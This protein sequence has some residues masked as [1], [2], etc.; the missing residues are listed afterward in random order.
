MIP[1]FSAIKHA[2]WT[3]GDIVGII[4]IENARPKV[5]KNAQIAN[6]RIAVDFLKRPYL[7][8]GKFKSDAIW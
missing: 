6:L 4:Y 3:V 7:E 5:R 2:P 1:A 8:N